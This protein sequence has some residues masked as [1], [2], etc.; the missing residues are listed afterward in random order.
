MFETLTQGLTALQAKIVL[1]LKAE[2][3]RME[4]ECYIPLLG[5]RTNFETEAP[6]DLNTLVQHFLFPPKALGSGNDTRVYFSSISRSSS[7]SN[8]KICL[9]T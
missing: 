8:S 7:K 6:E 5:R 2:L 4:H 3:S 9:G 1:E